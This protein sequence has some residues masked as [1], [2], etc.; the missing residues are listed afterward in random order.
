M[1]DNIS[2]TT[3]HLNDFLQ[4]LS[5]EDSRAIREGLT[6]ETLAIYDLLKKDNLTDK[7]TQKVKELAKQTLDKLKEKKLRL[8]YWRE[9]TKISSQVKTTISDTLMYLPMDSY[10]KREVDEKANLVY[11]HIFTSYPG[12]GTS[13]YGARF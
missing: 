13:I 7:E 11:Q 10:P 5:F 12:G 2:P 3:E 1:W 4:T 6:E 8:D 9:S